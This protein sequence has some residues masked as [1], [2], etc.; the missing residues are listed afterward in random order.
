MHGD[1][2]PFCFQLILDTENDNVFHLTTSKGKK[3]SNRIQVIFKMVTE[4]KFCTPKPD[5]D[6]CMCVD[7]PLD[8]KIVEKR[9]WATGPLERRG[10][11]AEGYRFCQL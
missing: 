2:L 1:N 3:W 5:A 6:L 7:L 10:S 9:D 11:R 4:I 8:K